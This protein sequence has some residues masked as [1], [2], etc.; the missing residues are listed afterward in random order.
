MKKP[1]EDG[2]CDPNSGVAVHVPWRDIAE[3]CERVEDELLGGWND[4]TQDRL[5]SLDQRI[6]FWK[7]KPVNDNGRSS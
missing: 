2:D 1:G 4:C 7:K 5:L 6:N 3:E